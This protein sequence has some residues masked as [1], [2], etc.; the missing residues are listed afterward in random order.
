MAKLE[1]IKKILHSRQLTQDKIIRTFGPETIDA[2]RIELCGT[3]RWRID[4]ETGPPFCEHSLFPLTLDGKDCPYFSY[5]PLQAAEDTLEDL[6][7]T[8]GE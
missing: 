4:L 1:S 7:K 5:D 2:K 3:C 8:K 6:D